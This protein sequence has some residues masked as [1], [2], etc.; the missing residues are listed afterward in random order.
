MPGWAG[1][2]L[3]DIFWDFLLVGGCW[4]HAMHAMQAMQ[5]MQVMQVM[6]GLLSSE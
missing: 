4:V 3:V 5:S 2:D 6:Q 1:N